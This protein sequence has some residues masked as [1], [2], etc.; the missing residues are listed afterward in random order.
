MHGYR[1]SKEAFDP[2]Q[3]M[4]DEDCEENEYVA[5]ESIVQRTNSKKESNS[6][7]LGKQFV[8]QKCSP[9]KTIF[10]HCSQLGSCLHLFLLAFTVH[11]IR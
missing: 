10:F 8:S 3:Q 7:Q 11:N 4:V 1:T 6:Y 9:L 5:Q 2:K